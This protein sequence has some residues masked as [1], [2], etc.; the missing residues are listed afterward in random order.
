MKENTN[1]FLNVCFKKDLAFLCWQ[2][3]ELQILVSLV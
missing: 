3:I 2:I 1:I